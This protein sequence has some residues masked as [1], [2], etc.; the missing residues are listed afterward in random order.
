MLRDSDRL[1]EYRAKRDF[2][3]TPEP[4]P[5][6]AKKSKGKLRYLIQ[7][8]AARREHYD[9][10]L[11]HNGALLS[12]AVPRGPSLDTKEKR[13]AV[14]TEDH[15]IEYGNFEGTIPE[16]EYGGG[17]VML[18][19]Q[20]TWEPRLDVDQGLKDGQLKL[21]L[22]GKRLQ[23][24]WALVRLR[25][26]KGDRGKQNWLLIKERDDFVRV[27][28]RPL[29]EREKT[30]VKS[31]R[32]MGEIARGKKVWHS[33]R[34]AKK[35]RFEEAAAKPARRKGKGLKLPPFV[36][37]QLATYVEG[38]PPGADWVH[39]IK[40][41][42]YRAVASVAD[43]KVVIRTRTGLDWT[44]RF[45]HLVPAL[46]DLPCDAALLDGEI[47]VA[48]AKGHT[49]FGAL[50]DALSSGRGGFNY[51]LFDLLHLDGEDLRKRPL[52]KRKEAL[53]KLL[54]AA[55][56]RGPLL[57][58]DHVEGEGE[59]VF[60]RARALKLEGIISKQADAPYRS[61]RTRSWLKS[62]VGDE[63]ELVIIG[64][65]P[66]D[67]P[68]RPFSSLLL[69]VNEDGKLR[70]AG[71]VGTG[72]SD[73][74]LD[75][76]AEKFAK[77][78]RK[79]PPV[80]D[81]PPAIARRARF[82]E[83]VLV[84]E[85]EFRGWTRD[86][87]V[88]QGAFKGLR[89][90]KP[91]REIVREKPMPKAKAMKAATNG[92]GAEKED[93]AAGVRITHPERVLWPDVGVTKRDLVDYY[94]KVA[95]L[96][97]PHIKGR[98]LALVRTPDGVKGERFFQKHASKGW[99]DAFKPIRIREKSG[100]DEYMYIEDEAGLVAAAQMSVVELHILDS[101]ADN[102]EHPDRLVFDLDPDEEI[103]FKQVIAAANDMRKR[104][105][106]LGLKSF[107]MVTGGKGIHVVVPLKRGHSWEE[108][109]NFAEALARL[110]AEEDPDRYIAVM[111]K[112]KRRGKIFIDYLRNQ[113]GSTAIAP[114]S[115]RAKDSASIALPVSWPAL[116]K[117]KNAQPAHVD[118][119]PPRSD[120]W[121]GYFQ[122][123]QKLPT[124]KR[125][126]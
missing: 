3:R 97:L 61:G 6:R 29:V 59:R 79:T 15:P 119:T 80:P 22:H 39:E 33:N 54:D 125:R 36:E 95:K 60:E 93:S 107:P 115:S 92:A 62:K 32:T 110:M 35:S 18:W 8:H 50:Q 73:Q 9:F 4:A 84:A 25:A 26:R 103:P 34:P 2:S 16:G 13:L 71:R 75:D 24:G 126:G 76:L 86:N 77:H 51:Y 10:R 101:L 108:H 88:R 78:A 105:A 117:L 96:M 100:S 118:D 66:S 46:A 17:T 109:R 82:V 124:G 48:D 27:E 43:G 41:D 112:A 123:K 67:K 20:G 114:Y 12:W 72:F 40:Y 14:R 87:L 113:R 122:V 81:V 64:W 7:K 74:R 56:K 121:K 102:V 38:P 68:R 21:N 45:R 111:S 42:G 30:S 91:A 53:R 44:D 120:P 83:P 1:K 69:A 94:L 31:G 52:L 85:I 19:D 70:Y 57:F 116:G 106:K 55:S 49:D 23:G 37:P 65:R 89:A 28:K 11:E 99:P 5:K 104:L 90:D 58:S 47:A 98:P 63:Q